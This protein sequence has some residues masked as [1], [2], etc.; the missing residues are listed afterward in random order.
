MDKLFAT[1]G[2]GDKVTQPESKHGSKDIWWPNKSFPELQ[3]P[4]TQ[5]PIVNKKNE[6][7]TA[8]LSSIS[9]LMTTIFAAR[10]L[11]DYKTKHK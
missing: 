10:V 1:A 9:V 2:K 6:S 11:M 8:R 3:H 4:E 5:L 7:A